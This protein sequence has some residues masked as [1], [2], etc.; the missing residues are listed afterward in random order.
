[1]ASLVGRLQESARTM[2]VEEKS[3]F[4]RN[5]SD[6]M[7]RLATEVLILLC[8]IVGLRVIYML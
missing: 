4:D 2:M 6:Y 8:S 7:M 5:C 3:A 1:M